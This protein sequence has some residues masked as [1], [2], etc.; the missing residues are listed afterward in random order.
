MAKSNKNNVPAPGHYNVLQMMGSKL[1]LSNSAIRQEGTYSQKMLKLDRITCMDNA[2][3]EGF[4]TPGVGE[5][6]IEGK[7]P[8]LIHLD[9]IKDRNECKQTR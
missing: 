2:Q 1:A 8:L 6:S 9:T 7:V 3:Y 4:I 5:Y